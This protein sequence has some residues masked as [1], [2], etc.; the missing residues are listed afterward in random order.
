TNGLISAGANGITAG[1]GSYNFTIKATDGSSN[2]YFKNMSINV[3]GSPSAALPRISAGNYDDMVV[4]DG[5]ST[6][7]G[8][9]SGGVA[10]FQWNVTGLPAGVLFRTGSGVT[11]NYVSPGAVEIYG[12]PRTAG[13]YNVVFTVT[14]ANLATSS[15][16]V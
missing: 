5:Y 7:I 15:L 6:S 1:P 11:A 13:N 2:S 14:D 4:G 8:I 16:T 9:S 3:I 10:P 12:F